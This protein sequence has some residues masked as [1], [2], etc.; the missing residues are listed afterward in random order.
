MLAFRKQTNQKK[1]NKTYSL[2]TKFLCDIIDN[3]H[4]R[5]FTEYFV[6]V[7]FLGRLKKSI[8]ADK[9]DANM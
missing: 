2:T 8:F 1:T 6:Q 5:N 4:G 3:K 9:T 7:N